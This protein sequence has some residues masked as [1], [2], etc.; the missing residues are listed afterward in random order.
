VE[1]VCHTP[2]ERTTEG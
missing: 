1:G 2:D